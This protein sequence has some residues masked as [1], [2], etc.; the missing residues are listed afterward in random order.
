[1][2]TASFLL[3]F[4]AATN[5]ALAP[6][7]AYAGQGVQPVPYNPSQPVP[8]ASAQ[9]QPLPTRPPP[10]PPPPSGAMGGNDVIVLKGGG[11]LRGRIIEIIPND[12]ATIALATGQNAIVEWGR[13]DRIEQQPSAPPPP[14]PPPGSI[15]V[16]GPPPAPEG[17]Q[18]KVWVHIESGHELVLEGRPPSGSFGPVCNE[19]CDAELPLA[20]TYRLTGSGIRSSRD[21]TLE[22]APGQHVVL[23]VKTGSKGGFTGGIVL[24][25]VGPALALIGLLV[26][27]VG[28]A[29][30]ST[31]NFGCGVGTGTTNSCSSNS[32][33][34]S[35]TETT[36]WVMTLIGLGATVG[37]I[38]LIVTNARTSYTEE[39]MAP[40]PRPA[41]SLLPTLPRADAWLRLPTW[42]EPSS[43]ERGLPP[44][45]ATPLFTQSF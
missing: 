8:G 24:V 13:I 3:A 36:G 43:V 45:Q 22:A 26:V 42:H 7:V 20:Y 30:N 39:I 40:G 37:G 41:G 14:P 17:P 28:V 44:V 31:T 11:M 9:L 32:N 18:G 5:V 19:P 2:R 34:G 12:H 1:M 23:T 21:F 38:V 27:L 4:A 6:L 29:E 15:V 35:G 25:S 33:A 10:P 16:V